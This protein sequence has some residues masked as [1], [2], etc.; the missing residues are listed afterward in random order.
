MVPTHSLED[1]SLCVDSQKVFI[2]LLTAVSFGLEFMF[3][4][5]INLARR[6]KKSDVMMEKQMQRK[7]H[8]CSVK[9]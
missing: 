4:F 5:Y 9:C 8:L 7:K 2:R 3:S 6:P 1:F